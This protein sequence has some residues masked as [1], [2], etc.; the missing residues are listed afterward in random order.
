MARHKGSFTKPP[1][2]DATLPEREK[3]LITA[4]YYGET[5]IARKMVDE[6]API[7]TRDS[8][9]SSL[10][11]IAAQQGHIDLCKELISHIDP[12]LKNLS[13]KSALMRSARKGHLEIS[14]MLL[15][16]GAEI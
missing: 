3:A 8:E 2:I 15:E 7:P 13:G 11:L 9:G 4:V 5:C 10:L 16:N 12:N 1:L 6:G 14:R